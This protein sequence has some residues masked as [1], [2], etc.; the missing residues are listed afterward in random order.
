M[1]EPSET[2]RVF[3]LASGVDFP[4]ALVEGLINRAQN[5]PKETLA[6]TLLIVNTARMARRIRDLFDRGP[7]LLMPKIQLLT[8]LE[9]AANFTDV[10]PAVSPLRRRLELVQLVSALLEQQPDLAPRSSLY[11]L[12]D[13]LATLMDEMHSEGVLP[14]TITSLDVSDQSGHWERAKSFLTIVHHYFGDTS[15]APDGNERQ[16]MIAQRLTKQWQSQPPEHPIII[17]GSTGSRGATHLLMQAVANLP[18]GALILPGYDFDMPDEIWPTLDSTLTCED[19][20]QFR[21]RKLMLA[22][23]ITPPDVRCWNENT[24]HNADRNRIVSLAL[25]PA[26]VTDQWLTEGPDLK[27]IPEAMQAVTLI[28]APSVRDEAFVIAMRLRQA[29]QDGQ[30]AALITPDRMLTR[31]VTAALERWNILP[32]DSAGIPLQLTPPGRFLRHISALFHHKLT[33]EALITLLKHPLTHV[34]SNPGNH[35]LHTQNL[36]LHIRKKGPPYPTANGLQIWA[37][38]QKDKNAVAWI[39]WVIACFIDKVDTGEQ[40]LSARISAHIALAEQISKGTDDTSEGAIW[41]LKPGQQMR[42]TIDDFIRQA[43]H[44]GD[45]LASDYSTLFSKVLA[46]AEGVRDRDA[47]HPNIL[48][49]GTMEARVQGADLL[50][51]AGLNDGVWPQSPAPDPWLNRKLRDQAGLLLPER[52]I[53]LSAHDFQ[54]A[55]GAPE[56]WLTRSVRSDDAQTIASRWLNRLLNLLRGLPDQGGEIALQSMLARGEVWQE[57]AKILQE[58]GQVDPARRPS[59]KPPVEARPR[60]LSVTEIKRLIRDPYAI[61]AKH[62][63]RLRPLRSLMQEPDALMRGIVIHEIFEAYVKATQENP[64]HNTRRDLMRVTDTILIKNIPWPHIR[65][66]WK[67]RIDR[68]ADWFLETEAARLANAKPAEFEIKGAIT[69][70][71]L[72]FKLTATADRIDR[73]NAG[74][75][76]IY[77]YKSGAI[78]SATEQKVFNKQL[79]LEAVIASQGGFGDMPPAHVERAQFVGVGSNRKIG[80]APLEDEPPEKV[81]EDFKILVGAYLDPKQGFTARRAMFKKEDIGDYDQLARYGEW[82]ITDAPHSSEMK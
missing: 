78:P 50:I 28:E 71:D 12:A 16:M 17:A 69:I 24:A 80:G 13:S 61:Y 70:P 57:R 22:L 2:P 41:L 29:A 43:P 64:N 38:N 59:P 40:S 35:H 52:R 30:I 31:Q 51:L 32:D 36:E 25:R 19:H 9:D 47:P 58:P 14:E 46:D 63:L 33:S 55:I 81:W 77:D 74:G 34:G 37:E 67:A 66:L 7:A 60:H 5:Q 73:D 75:L 54:Q 4:K 76:H 10:P 3:G 49:W 65:A 68:V 53:G 79:L 18:Q 62:V 45:L 48:I 42:N 39:K 72:G 11:D 82:D 27:N 20:P 8:N 56:V 1:F 26:P 23:D 21:F 6:R 15:G 44:S